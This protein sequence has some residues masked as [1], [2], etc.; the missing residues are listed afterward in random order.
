M[1]QP[2]RGAKP[3]PR[4]GEKCDNEG[5]RGTGAD[6]GRRIGRWPPRAADDWGNAMDE[7]LIQLW[8]TLILKRRFPGHDEHKASLVDFVDGYMAANPASRTAPENRDLFESDYGII[9]KYYDSVPAI[10]ALADFFVESFIRIS[11]AANAEEWQRRQLDRSRFHI[12]ITGSWFINYHTSG[13]VDPHVHRN[14]SW[15][16]V[17][18]LQVAETKGARD[19]G[20]F[21]IS[22]FNKS[23]SDDWGSIYMAEA[24]RSFQ[25]AE[26]QALFFPSFLVHGS[27]P[28][29]GRSSRIIF[30]SN[31]RISM[32]K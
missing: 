23:D 17:Y 5:G 1:A 20:T 22:P 13:N 12:E 29:Q 26:G 28:Y 16:C 18:Y 11:S 24:S 15:S 14:C 32:R 2:G 8:P 30:S 7:E 19:G 4:R 3:G 31:A 27:H 6:A 25:A 10:R 21:F 9:P